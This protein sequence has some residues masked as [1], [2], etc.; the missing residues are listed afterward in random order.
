MK[1]VLSTRL[2]KRETGTSYVRPW[3]STATVPGFRAFFSG[4]PI[5]RTGRNRFLRNVLIAIG[6]SGDRSLLA[7]AKTLLT[8]ESPLV[9]GAAV[10]AS[11][12]L[13]DAEDFLSLKKKNAPAENDESVSLEWRKGVKLQTS[14]VT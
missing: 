5:K 12:Q 7:Q 1:V 11:S 10:W 2:S 6:N 4:S 9:R 14:T 13:A 8:D 3:A